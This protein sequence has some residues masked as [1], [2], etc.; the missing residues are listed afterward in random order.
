LKL[1]SKIAC[2]N[3][4]NFYHQ[5]T[6]KM[7]KLNKDNSRGFSGALGPAIG[8]NWKGIPYLRAKPPQREDKP[9]PAQLVHRAKFAVVST[10]VYNFRD[11]LEQTYGIGV[12]KKTGSNVALSS[13]F[14]NAVSGTYPNFNINYPQVMMA[15]GNNPSSGTTSIDS[16]EQGMIRFSWDDLSG[17]GSAKPTDR[18][19]LVA[20]C[21]AMDTARYE[22]NSALRE[23]KTATLNV[24]RFSGMEFHTWLAF[25]SEDGEAVFTSVYGGKVIV[26]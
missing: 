5:K 22:T 1:K 9:T 20:Y 7:A 13:I 2:R 16:P 21:E 6:S 25:I 12:E 26:L 19:I 4:G 23:S 3:N 10:F 8:A 24:S 18:S 17:H 11:L 15:N 14:K